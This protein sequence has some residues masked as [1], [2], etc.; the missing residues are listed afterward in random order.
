MNI[1][2]IRASKK[3]L[4]FQLRQQRQALS[5]ADMILAAEKL[6]EQYKQHFADLGFYKI[7]LYL[8]HDNELATTALIDLLFSKD[9]ELY[10]PKIDGNNM[11]FCRYYQNHQM[12]HNQFGIAEPDTTEHLKPE[13]LD[14][15]LLPLTAF[16]LKGN[17]LGMGGGYY[18]RALSEVANT[19]TVIAGLAYD[20][21]EVED[22]PVESF[23]KP[24]Q[25]LLT[26]TRIIEFNL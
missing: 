11:T 6:A 25:R 23:D 15:I 7:A 17:R 16:D 2:A 8:Q 21:Q 9:C 1:H 5:G 18:D 14:L 20:F 4:R 24:M 22:C 3:Q 13:Q 26:P 10:L 12:I 19:K